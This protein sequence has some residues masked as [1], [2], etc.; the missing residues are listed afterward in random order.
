MKNTITFASSAE[1]PAAVDPLA[2][3]NSTASRSADLIPTSSEAAPVGAAPPAP[4]IAEGTFADA[5][6]IFLARRRSLRK[7]AT[8]ATTRQS[9]KPSATRPKKPQSTKS[10]ILTSHR[11]VKMAVNSACSAPHIDESLREATATFIAQC[12]SSKHPALRSFQTDASQVAGQIGALMGLNKRERRLHKDRIFNVYETE[13]LATAQGGKPLAIPTTRLLRSAP[14]AVPT[15]PAINR[16]PSPSPAA[17][18]TPWSTC[19]I[20]AQN[21]PNVLCGNCVTRKFGNQEKVRARRQQATKQVAGASRGR[22]VLWLRC[23]RAHQWTSEI[24]SSAAEEKMLSPK[25]PKCGLFSTSE[26]RLQVVV[27]ASKTCNASCWNARLPRCVC[28][29]AGA[30]HG[31][32]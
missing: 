13:W 26:R 32:G 17:A 20:C 8:T 16:A 15:R 30:R 3:P 22:S 25:C 7:T 27:S 2:N 31:I 5:V 19:P 1:P 21:R 18:P 29:C 4:N 12:R 23:P 14:P 10:A 24:A 6:A 9:S 11:E 28:S